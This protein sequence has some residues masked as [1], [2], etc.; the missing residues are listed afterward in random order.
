MRTVLILSL[1]VDNCYDINMGA[2]NLSQVLCSKAL[3]DRI[4]IINLKIDIM[5]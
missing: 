5:S 3:L 2:T 1:S 4:A